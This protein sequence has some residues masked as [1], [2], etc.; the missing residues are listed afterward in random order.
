MF[1]NKLRYGN[2]P[3]RGR[4]ELKSDRYTSRIKIAL[5]VGVKACPHKIIH[6]V[7]YHLIVSQ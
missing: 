6:I 7:S 3:V 5:G 2:K 4:I 1:K